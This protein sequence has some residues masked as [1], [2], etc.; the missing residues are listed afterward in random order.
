MLTRSFFSGLHP[1]RPELWRKA[2]PLDASLGTHPPS[3]QCWRGECRYG[4][5]NEASSQ[6]VA[7]LWYRLWP[8]ARREL[9]FRVSAETNDLADWPATLVCPPIPLRMHWDA[10]NFIDQTTTKLLNPSLSEAYLLGLQDGQSMGAAGERLQLS[11]PS[12]AAVSRL[13]Q[14]V[15][16]LEKDTADGVRV[17][18]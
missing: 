15:T 3:V 6:L 8:E 2:K 13:E 1:V 7:F 9:R 4:S 18:V 12:I 11:L 14:Y 10:R 17:A 16:M 5:V